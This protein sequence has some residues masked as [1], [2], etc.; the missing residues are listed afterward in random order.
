MTDAPES[1]TAPASAPSTVIPIRRTEDAATGPTPP[2]TLLWIAAI[3]GIAA[4]LLLPRLLTGDED[5]AAAPGAGGGGRPGGGGRAAP[6]VTAVTARQETLEDALTATGSLL[7]WEEVAVSAEAAGRVVSVAFSEGSYVRRGQVLAVLNTDVIEAQAQAL[8]AQLDLARVQ[9]GRQQALYDIGGLSRAALDQSASQVRVLEAQLSQQR[10]ESGRRRIVAP[11]S[12]RMGLSDLSPGAYVSPGQSIGMLRVTSPLKLEF[13]VPERY[14][15]RI[16]T[17]AAV[18][19]RLPGDSAPRTAQVYALEPAVDAA[20]RA[21][22]VRARVGNPEGTLQPGTFAEV[23][24]AI[25]RVENALLVPASALTPGVDSSSVWVVRDGKA[26]RRR[27][28]TGVRTADDVQVTAGLAAGDSVLT[29]GFEELREGGAV[30]VA[31]DAAFDPTTVR[32]DTTRP[33][34]GAY[35]PAQ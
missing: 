19:F 12:G 5:E 4:L 13:A 20:T 24:L 17:G 14:A 1:P 2:K 6:T 15:G 10:A 18:D 34:S 35:R 28:A 33:A 29:S 7:A 11:F 31:R 32:P 25:D 30:R 16:R 21:F 26:S 3:L 9:L 22:T 8:Q 23:R 27:I